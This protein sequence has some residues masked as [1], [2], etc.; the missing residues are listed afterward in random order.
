MTPRR[1][2]QQRK[3]RHDPLLKVELS[4]QLLIETPPKNQMGRILA[5]AVQVQLAA[6]APP[7]EDPTGVH[8]FIKNI[9]ALLIAWNGKVEGID[10]ES[11]LPEVLGSIATIFKVLYPPALR[12]PPSDVRAARNFIFKIGKHDTS[13]EAN[14][15]K[16]ITTYRSCKD[17]FFEKSHSYAVNGLTDD[18]SDQT[19]KVMLGNFEKD[20]GDVYLNAMEWFFGGEG[21][22]PLTASSFT[23]KT[24]SLRAFCADLILCVQRWSDAKFETKTEVVVWS[25]TVLNLFFSSSSHRE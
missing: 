20:F 3:K 1:E 17:L 14:L 10:G 5:E 15:A 22:D 24:K 21:A 8:K 16:S 4:D 13:P 11:P 2:A 7:R 18:A 6:M 9:D 19:F 25:S 23:A 12:P